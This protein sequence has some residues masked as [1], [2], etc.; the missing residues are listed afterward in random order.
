M[1]RI[2]HSRASAHR[3]HLAVAAF[4]IALIAPIALSP[5]AQATAGPSYATYTGATADGSAVKARVPADWNGVLL[6]W[7][8]GYQQAGDP[9]VPPTS[10]IATDARAEADAQALL[11][12]GFA[13]AG[14]SYSRRGFATLEGVK[15]DEQ[16]YAWFSGKAG[17]PDAL[18]MW[19]ESL[20]GLITELFAEKHPAL[21]DGVLQLGAVVG[22]T[23]RNFD[24]S[25][26]Y[27]VMVKRLIDPSL[28]LTNYT[29][30]AEASTAFSHAYATILG[31]LGSTD[32]A[33]K[34]RMVSRLLAI[35]LLL[36]G[37][38]KSL[39]YDGV[40]LTNSVSAAVETVASGLFYSTV[41]RFEIEKRVG[42]NPSTNLTVDY[43]HRI[44]AA[45]LTRYASF[46]FGSALL[47]SYA[48]SVQTFGAR[49][50]ANSAARTKLAALGT[51]TGRITAPTVNMHTAY[52]PLVVVQNQRVFAGTVAAAGR[53]S[54]LQTFITVPPTTYVG[55]AP[56]GAG[57]VNFT[58]TE[59][60]GALEGLDAWSVTGTRTPAVAWAALI[61]PEAS[62]NYAVA[63]WPVK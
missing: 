31:A 26:D 41:D 33:V 50:A 21:V 42:G 18:Y 13:I 51:P 47:G 6:I 48:Q 49:V 27:E 20:G 32:N 63:A 23:L 35:Q 34:S 15:A 60:L 24:L 5:T 9:A 57:H 28:K 38:S 40:G 19:G 43:R 37:P 29:S 36:D 10:R 7:S 52:D 3:A 61:G 45:D 12:D 54:L 16:L 2:V 59:V 46:G 56:Y 14:S 39:H 30:Y 8:H 62:T 1:S 17:T 55:S 11:A 4:A 22:G 53:S 44:S 58:T 25:L